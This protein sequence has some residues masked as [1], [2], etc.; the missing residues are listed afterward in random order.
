MFYLEE[1]VPS[2]V[3]FDMVACI[4]MVEQITNSESTKLR[5]VLISSIYSLL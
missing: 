2:D 3:I 4:G 1:L 5:I